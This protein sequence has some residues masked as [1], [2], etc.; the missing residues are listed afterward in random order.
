MESIRTYKESYAYIQ[1]ILNTICSAEKIVIDYRKL[2]GETARYLRDRIRNYLSSI[3]GNY[4]ISRGERNFVKDDYKEYL[5]SLEKSNCTTRFT[6]NLEKLHPEHADAL[7]ALIKETLN[8][9]KR[10]VWQT[11]FGWSTKP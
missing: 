1:S 5:N 4:N 7:V 6:V 10:K 8:V 2:D 3:I 9:R 11:I